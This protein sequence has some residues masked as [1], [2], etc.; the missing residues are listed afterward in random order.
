[1]CTWLTYF[2]ETG[3]TNLLTFSVVPSVLNNNCGKIGF[4]SNELTY[5]S[6]EISGTN[7]CANINCWR[8][9]SLI[10]TCFEGWQQEE[11][12]CWWV[13]HGRFHGILP[14]EYSRTFHEFPRGLYKE[15][16]TNTQGQSDLTHSTNI[17]SKV[18][19]FQKALFCL[20]DFSPHNL[21]KVFF[22]ALRKIIAVKCVHSIDINE[23]P[24]PF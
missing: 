7:L 1:M 19:P 23:H 11:E 17:W 22:H 3:A 6:T 10:Q 15:M 24:S 20:R 2:F 12:C 9:L 4:L 21:K 13:C 5:I 16:P 18:Y 14:K 8:H